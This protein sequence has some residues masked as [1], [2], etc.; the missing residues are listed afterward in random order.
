MDHRIVVKRGSRDEAEKPFWISYADLMTALMML[1]LVTMSVALLAVTKTVS[2]RERAKADRERD[3]ERLLDRVET[4]AAKHGVT[5]DRTRHVIDFGD[6]ARFDTARHTLTAAQA[7]LLRAF[8]PEV[9]AVARDELG[10][11]W[12]KRIVAEGFADQRGTYLFNLNLSMQ[13]S[14]R[15]LCVL[16]SP[17]F[18]DEPPLSAAEREEIRE[19]FLVGGYSFNSAKS[20]LEA[21]RRIELRLEFFG[22][23]EERPT[24]GE[25]PRGDFGKCALES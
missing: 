16:L 8:V 5:V 3:I 10:H 17:P 1:F 6:R 11:R 19:L 2:E 25:I 24:I 4:A 22:A 20:S 18:E 15:V 23:E 13:R 21:S 12:L 9:L 14:Q 7:K